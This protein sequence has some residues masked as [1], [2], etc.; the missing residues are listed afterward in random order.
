MIHMHL[1]LTFCSQMPFAVCLASGFLI[2]CAFDLT[3][4]SEYWNLVVWEECSMC[5]VTVMHVVLCNIFLN[6]A[7]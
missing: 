3:G 4:A 1:F 6:F 2:L 7:E 5:S